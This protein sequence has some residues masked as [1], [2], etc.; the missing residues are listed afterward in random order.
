MGVC[1]PLGGLVLQADKQFPGSMDDE[2]KADIVIFSRVGYL[3]YAEPALVEASVTATNRTIYCRVHSKAEGLPS[4]L[5]QYFD[6]RHTSF[7][8]TASRRFLPITGSVCRDWMSLSPEWQASSFEDEEL[9][10]R[11]LRDPEFEL[12]DGEGFSNFA[13]GT[14]A[15]ALD[16]CL[17]GQKGPNPVAMLDERAARLVQLLA[18]AQADAQQARKAGYDKLRTRL[19][20]MHDERG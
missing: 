8:G 9:S 5:K 1:Q 6:L 19:R 15:A 13:P 20:A 4:L 11:V 14:I 10:S 2:T 16:Q 17:S 18:E 7:F 3:P 12:V